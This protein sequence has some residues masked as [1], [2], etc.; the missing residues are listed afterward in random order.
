M[1]MLWKITV[2]FFEVQTGI[3]F[4]INYNVNKIIVTKKSIFYDEN[5]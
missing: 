2:Y 1:H 3:G 5:T 4:Q